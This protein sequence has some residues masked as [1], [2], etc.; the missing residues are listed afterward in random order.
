M[1]TDREPTNFEGN[2]IRLSLIQKHILR[3]S[4][5]FCRLKIVLGL[6]LFCGMVLYDVSP[7]QA[8]EEEVPVE[9]QA[10]EEEVEGEQAVEA[11]GASDETFFRFSIFT[12]M[13]A[14][15]FDDP[16]PYKQMTGSKKF[17]DTIAVPQTGLEFGS[18][19]NNQEDNGEIQPFMRALPSFSIDFV[20]PL[21]LFIINGASIQYYH[22]S[23]IHYDAVVAFNATGPKSQTPLIKMVSYYD[24]LGASIHFFH[25]GEEG[26]D[27]F[28]GLGVLNIDGAYEG[29]FRGRI[30]NNFTRIVETVNFDAFPIT[31]RRVG[32]DVN[33][34]TFGLRFAVLV[35]S[36]AEVITDNVFIG[37]ELTPKAKKTVNFDGLILRAALTWRL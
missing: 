9:E 3:G 4:I 26:L 21:D 14:V 36:R 23:T 16:H 35:F 8:Q 28:A 34:E 37:N 15:R 7:L 6:L 30:E 24:F 10:V 11:G 29:G 20:V 25:P 32:L 2:S 19:V 27:I 22:T 33:G 18:R 5:R 13:F 17:D 1:E 12:E 31:Y